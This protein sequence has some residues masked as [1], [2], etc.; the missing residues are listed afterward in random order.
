LV[1]RFLS[2]DEINFEVVI[3]QNQLPLGFS[4]QKKENIN[5]LPLSAKVSIF[6]R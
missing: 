2:G 4:Q 1:D 6:E 3:Y 5:I